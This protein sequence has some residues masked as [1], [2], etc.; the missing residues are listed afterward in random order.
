M[1]VMEKGNR[2]V[3]ILAA[4]SSGPNLDWMKVRPLPNVPL[5]TP[6]PTPRPTPKP[7]PA[8]FAPSPIPPVPVPPPIGASFPE[9]VVLE[10]NQRL[11]R[12]DFVSSPN[13]QYK[14]GLTN[15]GDLELQ[16]GSKIIWSA[17]VSGGFRCFM[18]T[19]GN[20]ILRDSSNKAKW[21]S[22]T[23]G[24]RGAT[25]IV[26]DGGR[27]AVVHESIPIWLD[28]VPRGEYNGP[29][30]ADLQFPVRGAFYYPWYPQTWTVN[31]KLSHHIPYLGQYSSSDPVVA[32]NH[33]D[34]FEYA[35]ITLSIASWWGPETN[36]DRARLGLK[37]DTTISAGSDVKWTIYH[38]DQS[39]P[40]VAEIRADMDY[41]MKW[42]AWHPAWAH[43]DGRP[44]IFVYQISGCDDVKR[45]MD[46]SDGDWYVVLKLFPKYRNCPVQ[47]DSWHQYGVHTEPLFYDNVSFT[48]AP[49]FWRADKSTPMKPRMSEAAWCKDVKEMA[50]SNAKWHLIVSFNEAGEGTLIESSPDWKSGTPYGYY[51]DCL[52]DFE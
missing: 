47:A 40:S 19:D 2:K 24:H 32:A 42:F 34:A 39:K 11:N 28:G 10:S 52:H 23:F 30:S 37:M 49:G 27:I 14:F 20:L 35:H 7:T 38:E 44:V 16:A 46:A 12:G 6:Q 5:P 41:L 1:I 36:L 13:N 29:S 31:G 8:P 51:L 21:Q 22:R 50:A 45:W 17:G 43:V 25:L 3:K 15:K 33:I 48:I 9:S 26:D 4:D 18:Q